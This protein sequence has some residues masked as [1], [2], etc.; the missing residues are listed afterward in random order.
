MCVYVEAL[1]D[2]FAV[3]GGG[4]TWF[5]VEALADP[6]DDGREGACLRK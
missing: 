6:S 2:P 4:R 3:V 5:Y 1:A